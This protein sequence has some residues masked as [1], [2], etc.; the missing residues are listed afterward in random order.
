MFVEGE[1]FAQRPTLNAGI[2]AWLCPKACESAPVLV[3]SRTKSRVQGL[4]KIQM[5]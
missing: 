4:V 3:T 5:A 2:P 1:Q